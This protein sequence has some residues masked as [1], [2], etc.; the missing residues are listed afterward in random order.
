MEEGSID[1]FCP[2][3]ITV[4][5]DITLEKVPSQ[6]N[7]T[8]TN[9]C[10]SQVF[11]GARS[12]QIRLATDLRF[13]NLDKGQVGFVEGVIC[14]AFNILAQETLLNISESIGKPLM[15]MPTTVKRNLENAIRCDQL[16]RLNLSQGF[17]HCVFEVRTGGE[18]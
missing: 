16:Y 3:R 18:T 13:S 15:R 17:C 6:L 14:E 1:R 2:D 7:L 9:L 12:G 5:G 8:S 10:L 11:S 4:F